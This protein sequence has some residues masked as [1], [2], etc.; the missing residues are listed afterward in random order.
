MHQLITTEDFAV[1]VRSR[2]RELKLSQAQLAE[3]IGVSRQW[4]IDIEKGKPRAELA[5]VLSVLEALGIQLQTKVGPV[6][7]AVQI[8]AKQGEEK[9]RSLADAFDFI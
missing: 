8:D 9:I 6:K 4:V 5:L 2:R 3:Q 7:A 1:L